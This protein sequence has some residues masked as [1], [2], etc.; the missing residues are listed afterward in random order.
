MY[1]SQTA[2]RG[3]QKLSLAFG[4]TASRDASERRSATLSAQELRRIVAE[5]IG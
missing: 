1:V 5:H 3:R 4:A 2:G